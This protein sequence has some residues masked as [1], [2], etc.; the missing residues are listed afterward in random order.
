MDFSPIDLDDATMAFWRDVRA[1][2]DEHVTEEILEEERITGAGFS[3]PI[4]EAMGERGWIFPT[5]PIEAGGA[6]LDALQASIVA[7]ELNAHHVPVPAGS[8]PRD[9]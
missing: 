8:R 2:F 1:W 7:L 6:G 9:S 4:N 3:R 5:W